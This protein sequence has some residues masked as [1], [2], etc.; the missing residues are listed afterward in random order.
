[1]GFS[2]HLII[3]RIH[4]SLGARLFLLAPFLPDVV[5]EAVMHEEQRVIG[6]QWNLRH[7]S[8]DVVVDHAVHGLQIGV[9]APAEILETGL[10][11]DVGYG[12]LREQITAFTASARDMSFV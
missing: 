9:V 1:M 10:R 11:H 5:D 4:W 3:S 6:S 7:V 2:A 8:T 12:I